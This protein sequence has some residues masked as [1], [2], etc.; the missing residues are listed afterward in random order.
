MPSCDQ[1]HVPKHIAMHVDYITPGIKLLALEEKSGLT[2]REDW[3]RP[4]NGKPWYGP[5]PKQRPAPPAPPAENLTALSTCDI[6]ITPACV[7]ALYQ[8]PPHS[9]PP[10]PD[11][12]MGIFEAEL[13]FWAQ[14]D[15][16][17]LFANF[18]SI[19]NGTHPVDVLIDGGVAETFNLSMAGG[20][21][22]LDLMLSYP[23]V[24]P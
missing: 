16:N 13:Q 11:N 24:Y 3:P 12:S 15:L 7:A 10:N 14:E 18:T 4:P 19:P 21:A 22:E 5:H 23:I 6:E 20:E 17:S 9:V 2:R 8:I 1:Y